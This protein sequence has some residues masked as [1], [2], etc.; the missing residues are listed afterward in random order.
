ML[1]LSLCSLLYYIFYFE[2]HIFFVTFLMC[3]E[4]IDV[5]IIK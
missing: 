4:G 2:V 3:F 1:D 5:K